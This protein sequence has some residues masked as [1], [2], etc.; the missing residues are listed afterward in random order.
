[1]AKRQFG[2]IKCSCLNGLSKMEVFTISR[3][4]LCWIKVVAAISREEDN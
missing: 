4:G 3:I 2:G 1:M